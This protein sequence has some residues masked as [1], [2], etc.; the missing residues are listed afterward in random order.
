MSNKLG[1]NKRKTIF[2]ALVCFSA[3][4]M[5]AGV[6]VDFFADSGTVG[7]IMIVTGAGFG[8][9]VSCV[10]AVSLTYSRKNPQKR[11]QREINEKDERNIKIAEK[12]ALSTWYVTLFTL[13]ALVLTFQIL[14]Y[15][16]PSLIAVGVL[17]IHI[18]SYFIFISRNNKIL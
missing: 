2:I 5:I 7:S 13:T 8:C 15:S 18:I 6:L 12:S 10:A 3:A 1:F 9:G 16:T 14:D 17:L 11:K 4:L